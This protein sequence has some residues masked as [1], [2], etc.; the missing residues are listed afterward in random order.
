MM[1]KYID[2]VK[3]YTDGSCKPN[4][5]N[6]AIAYIILDDNDNILEQ[7][8]KPIGSSTNNKSEYSAIIEGLARCTAHTRG[9]VECHSDSELVIR[10]INSSYRIKKQDLLP[11]FDEVK[12]RE[13]AFNEVIYIHTRDSNEWIRR[14]DAL[15]KKCI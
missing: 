6:G 2:K 1:S 13:K 12:K 10:Q 9:C 7:S 3:L 8:S 11:F 15:S 14:V 5:G 4:P